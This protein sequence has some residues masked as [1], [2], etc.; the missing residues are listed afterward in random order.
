M[1]KFLT[2]FALGMLALVVVALI[3][4]ADAGRGGRLFLWVA[5]VPGGDKLGHVI[6]FGMLALL[7]NAALNASRFQWGRI[8]LLKGSLFVLVPTVLEEF[9]QLFF[10]RRSFELLDLLADGAGILLGGWLAVVLLRYLKLWT[11]RDQSAQAKDSPVVAS[12]RPVE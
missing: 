8:T 6:L 1:M 12:A 9:S 7:A 5:Q 2:W 10:W 11:S 3:Y 4:M